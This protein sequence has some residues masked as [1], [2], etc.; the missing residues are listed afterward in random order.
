M[1][2]CMHVR[3]NFDPR[4]Y[5]HACVHAHR[6]KECKLKTFVTI[7]LLQTNQLTTRSTHLS[8]PTMHTP[9]VCVRCMCVPKS[10]RTAGMWHTS[11]L[12]SLHTIQL[13]WYLR[14]QNRVVWYMP[15]C[16]RCAPLAPKPALMLRTWSWP[17]CAWMYV[18]I[19]VRVYVCVRDSRRMSTGF[20]YVCAHACVQVLRRKCACMYMYVYVYVY[21]CVCGDM[22]VR[23][24]ACVYVCTY[25]CLCVHATWHMWDTHNMV[26]W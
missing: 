25:M 1:H 4:V 24:Y 8:S 20:L 5:M 14:C 9:P 16:T 23:M 7:V 6:P 18:C 11:Q 13:T 15:V 17:R 12:P 21:V 22:R 10:M 19:R 3:L 2:A 26:V